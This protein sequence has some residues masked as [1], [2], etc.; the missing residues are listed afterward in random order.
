MSLFPNG[1]CPLCSG[2]FPREQLHEAW[3]G[4]HPRLHQNTILVIQ[5][6]HPGWVPDQGA[7]ETC[8]KS[9]RDAGRILGVLRAGRPQSR[10]RLWSARLGSSP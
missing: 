4:E 10:Q 7:C 6:Y 1:V 8:W 9:Y 5:A 2:I 3:A